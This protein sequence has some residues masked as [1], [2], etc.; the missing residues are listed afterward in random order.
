V[1][2]RQAERMAAGRRAVALVRKHFN[3]PSS[4]RSLALRLLGQG[5]PGAE[6][7][8]M[9][10]EAVG[11]ARAVNDNQSLREAYEVQGQRL[12]AASDFEP[13]AKAFAAALELHERRPL[14]E[15]YPALTIFIRTG[16]GEC[17][18][19]ALS[20]DASEA[21]LS[22]A[23]QIAGDTA[24][25]D[26]LDHRQTRWRRACT[27][28][29]AGRLDSALTEFDAVLAACAEGCEPD[30][31]TR[32]SIGI[33]KGWVLT[34]RGAFDA[35]LPLLRSTLQEIMAARP[36][37]NM[38]AV[39]TE[40]LAWALLDAGQHAEALVH[41]DA[42][43]QLRQEMQAQHDDPVW[44]PAWLLRSRWAA[45]GGDWQAARQ[46]LAGLRTWTPGVRMD[47]LGL[48]TRLLAF[49]GALFSADPA[50]GREA[51][52]LDAG[53]RELLQQ[54]PARGGLLLS[55]SAMALCAVYGARRGRAVEARAWTDA[56]GAL[57][58]TA[59]VQ[60]SARS[61]RL[62]ATARQAAADAA[63]SW[64]PSL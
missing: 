47:L 13:A 46:S 52:A 51:D 18:A 7:M 6:G 43:F 30:A 20:T 24:G 58:D 53:L 28:A 16:M 45:D 38:R 48:R 5:T 62:V 29:I 15:R 33:E 4:L 56:A 39:A 59:G 2:D 10:Q 14:H 3:Q 1:P 26:T 19:R 49:E 44:Q 34:E 54:Q 22:V 21:A 35:A 32:L 11:D 55:A 9:L 57:L 42:V 23:V 17:L 61:R 63:A 60:T 50:L 37:S 27:R 12:F 36:R 31:F 41:I 25:I 40:R 64:V 8:A